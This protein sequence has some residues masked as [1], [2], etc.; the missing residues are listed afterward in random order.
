MLQVPSTLLSPNLHCA[1]CRLPRQELK[2]GNAALE[3]ELFMERFFG[4][5]KLRAR[6]SLAQFLELSYMRN[7]L[8][9]E[10]A[11]LRCRAVD[12]CVSLFDRGD[13][14][15]LDSGPSARG[16]GRIVTSRTDAS[17]HGVSCDMAYDICRVLLLLTFNTC[18]LLHGEA[19]WSDNIRVTVHT[20][21]EVS[22]LRF[23][24]RKSASRS[25]RRRTYQTSFTRVTARELVSIQ[26][27]DEHTLHGYPGMRPRPRDSAIDGVIGGSV[28]VQVECYLS[29]QVTGDGHARVDHD[30]G[31]GG[32]NVH[33]AS[34]VRATWGMESGVIA[35]VQVMEDA[36]ASVFAGTTTIVSSEPLINPTPPDLFLVPV[37]EFQCQLLVLKAD[38][39]VQV[40]RF[41]ECPGKLD[42]L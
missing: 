13:S 30:R 15:G 32:Y 24:S 9:T 42:L 17:V 1:V 36:R 8:A 10:R 16:S 4:P 3:N 28:V 35:V 2:R 22:G 33:G 19:P 29:V 40:L 7:T 12:G 39:D 23:D 38:G 18:R 34:T 5:F 25:G 20:G 31:R 41:V 11:L 6:D 21:A 37:A 14:L 27:W 26:V